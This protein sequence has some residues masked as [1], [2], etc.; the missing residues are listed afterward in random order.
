VIL[1]ENTKLF[2]TIIFLC[3]LFSFLL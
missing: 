3:I 2:I 1:G